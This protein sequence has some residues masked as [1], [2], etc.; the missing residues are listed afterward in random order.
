MSARATV[1]GIAA[2]A[3]IIVIAWQAGQS[4]SVSTGSVSASGTGA[5]TTSPGTSTSTSTTSP[6]TSGSA[7]PSAAPSSSTSTTSVSG[8][9]T[10]SA[11]QTRYGN[12]QVEIVVASGK[13][14]D[15][16]VL[17][18]TNREQRSVEISS[19]AD[20]ILRSE[21]LQAQSANVQMVSGATYT[22]D[23]YLQ[24][25]QSALDKAKL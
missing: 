17:Q 2:S 14:T 1:G 5:A 24:S 19:Q 18:S 25:L 9:F 8:T 15:V 21:V 11:I 12:M 20:P 6:S 3:A 10:G 22:S 13:I 4:N 16:K 23:G 7:S